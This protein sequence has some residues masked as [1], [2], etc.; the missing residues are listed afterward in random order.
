MT[1]VPLKL[2]Y[3]TSQ[4]I[5]QQVYPTADFMKRAWILSERLVGCP[6]VY[7]TQ[8]RN[9]D[10]FITISAA[11]QCLFFCHVALEI[12]GPDSPVCVATRYRLDSQ[13]IESQWAV[14]ISAPV[15]T[16]PEA[17]PASCAMG[18]GV[19]AAGAWRRPPTQPR[20]EVKV[21]VEV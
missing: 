1:Y 4:P 17:H 18:N 13:G 16:G 8:N 10:T 9:D 14:R 6:D 20:A 5:D 3:M 15:Q 12:I 7:L 2:I 21:R 19:R 11:C